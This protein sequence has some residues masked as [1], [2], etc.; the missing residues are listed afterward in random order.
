MTK[1]KKNPG[2]SID[3][4]AMQRN[5]R[6]GGERFLQNRGWARLVE[7]TDIWVNTL[8]TGLRKHDVYIFAFAIQ[9]QKI[10]EQKKLREKNRT[11]RP[12]EIQMKES[13]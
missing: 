5:L 13:K 4:E 2:A 11:G 12:P 3:M 8:A 1:R 10:A 6:N 7:R 9:I